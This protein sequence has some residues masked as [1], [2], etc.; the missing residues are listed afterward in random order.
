MLILKSTV[1]VIET[2]LGLISDESVCVNRRK[3]ECAHLCTLVDPAF[4]QCSCF[5]F[6]SAN[7]V[8]VCLLMVDINWNASF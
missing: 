8:R 6:A 2:E 5:D 4:D 1:S 3:G 7:C